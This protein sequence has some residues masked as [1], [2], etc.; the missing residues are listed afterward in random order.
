MLFAA[1]THAHDFAVPIL[2]ACV[3]RVFQREVLGKRICMPG[4]VCRVGGHRCLR[5]P[6]QG[7]DEEFITEL[8]VQTSQVAQ[9][10]P[11]QHRNQEQV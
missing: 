3:A 11:T 6:L 7:G 8:P 2:V 4:R 10:M 9:A 1:A 5:P